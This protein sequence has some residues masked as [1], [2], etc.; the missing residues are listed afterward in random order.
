MS[1]K[2]ELIAEVGPNGKLIVTAKGTKGPECLEL[3]AFLHK[4]DGVE[5]VETGHT[6]DMGKDHKVVNNNTIL[7][8]D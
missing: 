1:K 4:I 8:K 2:V 6:E 5:V 7:E 3:L